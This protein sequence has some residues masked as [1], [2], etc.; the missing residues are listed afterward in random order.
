MNYRRITEKIANYFT[1][2]EAYTFFCLAIKS[3]R[4]TLD[5]NVKQQ[6]L[7]EYINKY[8]YTDK[9]R[10]SQ[11]TVSRHLS[12]FER[13][14]LLTKKSSDHFGKLGYFIKNKY[15]LETEHYVFIDEALVKLPIPN[16]LKG[17]LILVKCRCLNNTNFCGY[18]SYRRL[19]EVLNIGKTT[20]GK[21]LKQ[22]ID[23]G[24]IKKKDS[25]I[26][27]INKEIFIP[28]RESDIAKMKRFHGNA[29]TDEDYE[30]E[31]FSS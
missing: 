14:G 10:T 21:Y 23:L 15:Q 28:S 22:A 18:S 27:L 29:M 4:E 19:S 25:G 17:F 6:T 2:T 1:P 13:H 20:V 16:K 11:A 3:D 8:A 5:S 12:E 24:Y 31:R 9:D 30:T 26:E 7:V